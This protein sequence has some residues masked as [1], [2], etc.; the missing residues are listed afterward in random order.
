MLTVF[1]E[2]EAKKKILKKKTQNGQLK[3]SDWSLGE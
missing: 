1:H 3:E 2:D